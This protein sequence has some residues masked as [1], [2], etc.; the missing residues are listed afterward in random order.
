MII[1][2]IYYY[3]VNRQRSSD[4]QSIDNCLSFFFININIIINAICK[5]FNQINNI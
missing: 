4:I 1:I 5:Q 3:H 2:I